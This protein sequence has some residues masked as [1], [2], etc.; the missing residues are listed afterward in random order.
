L[1][2]KFFLLDIKKKM[3]EPIY[4]DLILENRENLRSAMANLVALVIISKTMTTTMLLNIF[5]DDLLFL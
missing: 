4:F 3:I 1:I 2:G 5:G